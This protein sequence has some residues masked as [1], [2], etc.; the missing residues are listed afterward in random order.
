[1]NVVRTTSLLREWTG[2]LTEDLV[3]SVFRTVVLGVVVLV[4]G[5]VVVGGGA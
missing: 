1:M 3:E 5:V 2:P 4:V